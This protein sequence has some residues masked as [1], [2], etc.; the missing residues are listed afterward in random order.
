MHDCFRHFQ[1]A[2]EDIATCSSCSACGLGGPADWEA[3]DAANQILQTMSLRSKR[4]FLPGGMPAPLSQHS[5]ALEAAILKSPTDGSDD[6]HSQSCHPSADENDAGLPMLPVLEDALILSQST[7]GDLDIEPE[8]HRPSK[9][10]DTQMSI[11]A[12]EADSWLG[13]VASESDDVAEEIEFSQD[14]DRQDRVWRTAMHMVF[15]LRDRCA[16]EG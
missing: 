14:E 1:I 16:D 6:D 13:M 9:S 15:L 3:E 10:L 12:K 7:D 2:E 11:L 5:L 8:V 4:G